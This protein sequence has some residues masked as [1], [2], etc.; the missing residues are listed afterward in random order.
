M[1][2][3]LLIDAPSQRQFPRY[4]TSGLSR[5][6]H[7]WLLTM[8]WSFAIIAVMGCVYVVEKYALHLKGTPMRMVANPAEISIRFVGFSHYLVSLYFMATSRAVRN[9]RGMLMFALFIA[10]SALAGYAFWWVGGDTN[11][12]AVVSVFI[13]FLMHALRDEVMF[14]RIRSGSA[15]SAAEAPLANRM[16]F[17]LQVLGLCLLAAILYPAF[18]FKYLEMGKSPIIQQWIDLLLPTQWPKAAKVLV[19]ASPFVLAASLPLWRIQAQYPGGIVRLL[20]SHRPLTFII[21]G[22]FVMAASTVFLGAWIFDV[23]ILMHFVGWYIF[24]VDGILKAPAQQRRLI[25]WRTPDAWIHKNLTGFTVFHGG[26]ALL[27]L[28][29]IAF[30]HWVLALRPWLPIG[31]TLHNP[32]TLFLGVHTFYYWTLAHL[33]IGFMPRN[34]AASRK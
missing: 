26:L 29:A 19:L 9:L 8:F 3:P 15:I 30:N 21:G 2:A 28:F 13:F 24:A 32:I 14:Y 4:P 7:D 5:P 12:L 11:K 34:R 23:L 33:V 6:V 25:T 1:T 22:T 17:H 27:F 20:R 10:L 16:F 18:L 31:H